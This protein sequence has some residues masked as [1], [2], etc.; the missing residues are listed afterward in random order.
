MPLLI[1]FGT[2]DLKQFWP[3]GTSDGDTAHVV[4]D[5]FE[6]DGKLTKAFEGATVARKPVLHN[7]AVTV[8]WQ[9]IDAPELHYGQSTWYRQHW[10]EAPPVR[11]AAYLQNKGGGASA[12]K[13]QVTTRVKKPNDVFDK[14]GRFIGD[15]MLGNVNLNLWMLEAGWAFPALYNSLEDDEIQAFLDAAKKGKSGLLN[16][17]IADL[18]VWDPNLTTPR[19]EPPDT[20]YDE[21]KDKGPVQFPKLFRRIVKFHT[22][23][24]SQTHGTLKHYLETQKEQDRVFKTDEFLEQG[25][26]TP[27][28]LLTD[29]ISDQDHFTATP[30]G[31]VYKEAPSTLYGP[32]NQKV[33]S[34]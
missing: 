30:A 4:V 29:F 2:L 22:D 9:G 26:A 10:G 19:K 12:L 14:Y 13:V 16:N 8:R 21:T 11:L 34:W 31:L 28:H 33:T 3:S 18:T 17:Y 1:A 20:K 27:S 5:R 15:V 7:G 25:R 32:D 23:K 6:Y 24:G